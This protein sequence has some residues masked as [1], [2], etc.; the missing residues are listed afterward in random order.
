MKRWKNMEYIKLIFVC[1]ELIHLND[2]A[3]VEYTS[4]A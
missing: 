1:W 2:R 3:K 4:K